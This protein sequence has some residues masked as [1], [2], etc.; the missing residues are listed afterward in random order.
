MA[1]QENQKPAEQTA[2]QPA[3][4]AQQPNV[5]V[6]DPVGVA[7][8]DVSDKGVVYTVRFVD[9]MGLT[10]D[11]QFNRE[12]CFFN[13]PEKVMKPLVQNGYRFNTMLDE[14]GRVL[15]AVFTQYKPE[16]QAVADA[17]QKL[18]DGKEEKAK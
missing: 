8:C 16:A 13:F 3:Q 15:Q 6:C 9:F 5:W 11:M 1:D 4:Q 7:H 10:H 18:K 14:T 2:E 17:V 12:D